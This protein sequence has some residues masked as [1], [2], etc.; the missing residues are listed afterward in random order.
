MQVVIVGG[1]TAG[2]MTAG[3]M[4][5]RGIK[6]TLVESE[7]EPIIGVGESITPH[8]DA[9]MK[10]LGLKESEW[11]ENTGAIHKLANKFIDWQYPGHTEYFSFTYPLKEEVAFSK[12]FG[13]SPDDYERNE[14]DT[15]TTDHFLELYNKSKLD[16]FDKYFNPQFHFMEQDKF[17]MGQLPGIH[18]TANHIDADKTGQYIKNKIAIPNGTTHI[19]GDVINVSVN[20]DTVTYIDVKINDKIQRI[21]SDWFID[22][23]GFKKILMTELGAQVVKFDDYPINSALVC[24]I[25]YKDKDTELKNY[26]QTIAEDYGWTFKIGL[27][28]RIGTGFCYNDKFISDEDAR[29]FFIDKHGAEPRSIKWTPQRLNTPIIGNTIAIGLSAGFIEP[30]EANALYSICQGASL[31]TETIVGKISADEYN[32]KVRSS[33]DNIYK[34]L[35]VH[36]TLTS[37]N[38]SEFWKSLNDRGIKEN[39]AELV[40]QE[41]FNPNNSIAEAF[42][43]GFLFPDYMWLQFAI[44]WGLDTS[45]WDLKPSKFNETDKLTYFTTIEKEF[46]DIANKQDSYINGYKEWIKQ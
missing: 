3:L 40:K 39:H 6:V 23:T 31:A 44:S 16:K 10:L 13:T 41:Y 2:W 11:M 46:L 45:N 4:S 37:S 32:E 30:L 28:S 14:H 25:P 35:L 19:I 43:W 34:F 18:P 12:R 33:Y 9:F 24:R 42:N 5:Q 29:Q 38:R 22:C 1:G 26:T 36:Y 27:D 7:N 15:L 17:H 21:Y 8:V 20:N